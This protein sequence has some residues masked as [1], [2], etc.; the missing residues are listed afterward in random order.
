MKTLRMVG[1]TVCLLLL[2]QPLMACPYDAEGHL[3]NIRVIDASAV[4][5]YGFKWYYPIP[6]ATVTATGIQKEQPDWL[7]KML[8]VTP[9]ESQIDLIPHNMT[10]DEYGVATLKLYDVMLYD[11]AVTCDNGKTTVFKLY[12]YESEYNI[13]SDCNEIQR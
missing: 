10:T 5:S 13:Y 3:V 8:G 9:D 6:N 1:I 11:V 2:M 7:W 4:D 12:P